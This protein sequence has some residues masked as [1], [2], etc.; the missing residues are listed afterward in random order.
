LIAT[1]A[2]GLPLVGEKLVTFGRISKLSALKPVPDEFVTLIGPGVADAG[3]VAVID[4]CESVLKDAAAPLNLTD[5]IVMNLEPVIVTI[6][7]TGALAGEK[8]VTKGRLLSEIVPV[9]RTVKTV[10]L[11]APERL[12]K[13]VSAFSFVV[14]PFTTTVT[15]WLVVPGENVSV[16]EVAM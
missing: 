16:P 3:T 13:K 9:P 15:V 2:P 14:S 10:A 11:T 5:V 1:L 6:A 4:V 12:T 7:P 8:P